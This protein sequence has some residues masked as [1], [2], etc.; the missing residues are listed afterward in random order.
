[1]SFNRI[2][3]AAILHAGA[4]RITQG[5]DWACLAAAGALEAADALICEHIRTSAEA[6]RRYN[7]WIEVTDSWCPLT[8]RPSGEVKP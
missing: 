6:E 4:G 1:M 3:I 5:T 7:K 2:H 8:V